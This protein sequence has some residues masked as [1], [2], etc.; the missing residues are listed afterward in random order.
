MLICTAPL[1]GTVKENHTSC[2]LYDAHPGAGIPAVFVDPTFVPAVFTQ[3][4]PG[5]REV[6]VQGL[7]VAKL[8]VDRKITE[9]S[10]HFIAWIMF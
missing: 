9:S 1:A 8:N 5:V 6:A 7:S 10:K 2:P 4:A 3:A